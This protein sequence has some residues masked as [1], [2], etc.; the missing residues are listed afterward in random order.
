[1]LLV[2]VLPVLAGVLLLM[3]IRNLRRAS[4]SGVSET[5]GFVLVLLGLVLSGLSVYLLSRNVV[6][7]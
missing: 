6:A 3:G 1:M 7:R 4:T 2:F 5:S